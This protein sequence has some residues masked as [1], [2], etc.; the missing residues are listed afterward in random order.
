MGSAESGSGDE[1]DKGSQHSD[2]SVD[3]SKL[4]YKRHERVILTG[5]KNFPHLIGTY[6]VVEDYDEDDN[7]YLV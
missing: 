6:G 5:L 1:L 3:W 2:G 7:V 4:K